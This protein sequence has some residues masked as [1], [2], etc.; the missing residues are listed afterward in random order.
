MQKAY[1]MMGLPGSGKTTW[2]QEVSHRDGSVI[3]GRDS[4]R[5]IIRN[6]YEYDSSKESQKYVWDISQFM[7]KEA[8][9]RGFNVILDQLSLTRKQRIETVKLLRKYSCENVFPDGHI[10]IILVYCSESEKNVERRMKSDMRWGSKE[11]YE[12]LIE[13][14][15]FD[16][17]EPDIDEEGFDGI[18]HVPGYSEML[19]K[20]V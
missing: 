2:A 3:V 10:D 1:V 17:E 15:K 4:I 12:K 16:M 13:K 7:I 11:Y 8:I 14:M 9:H 18:I 5:H 19:L 20:G 6:G